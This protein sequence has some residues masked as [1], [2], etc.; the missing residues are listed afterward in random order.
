MG[1]SRQKYWSGLAFPSPGD[2]PSPGV[3]PRSLALQA[4]SILFELPGIMSLANSFTSSFLIWISFIY[5]SCLITLAQTSS[6]MLNRSDENGHP[7]LVPDL[8]GKVFSLSTLSRMLVVDLSY[9][10]FIMLSH[11]PSKSVLL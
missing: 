6:T 2:L 9:M 3:E 11:I 8:R 1:I 5:F 7:C 4:V 10:A